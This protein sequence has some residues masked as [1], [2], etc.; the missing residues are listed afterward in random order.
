MTSAAKRFADALLQ[1]QKPKGFSRFGPG[2]IRLV[3]G[4]DPYTPCMVYLK[5][6]S[7]TY[8]CAIDEGSV[9]GNA[10]TNK[11]FDWLIDFSNQAD[12]HIAAVRGP[13]WKG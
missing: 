5:D 6:G 2:G 12:Q 13:D 3:F 10:L 7:A 1:T 9:E 8:D 11:Q 4:N